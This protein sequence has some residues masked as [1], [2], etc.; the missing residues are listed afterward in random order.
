MS[1]MIRVLASTAMAVLLTLGLAGTAHAG[2]LTP[3]PAPGKVVAKLAASDRETVAVV[4]KVTDGDTF[5]IA[6]G[7]RVRVLGIDSCEMSTSGGKDAK[8]WADVLLPIG[9][10][11]T[12]RAEP[13]GKDKDKNGRLLRYVTLSDGQDFGAAMVIYD[14]TGIYRNGDPKVNDASPAEV[15]ALRAL[16]DGPRVCTIPAAAP[17]DDNTYVPAP[18]GNGGGESR[19]CRKRWWC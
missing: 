7:Q 18:N 1:T 11:V 10:Q 17:N 14:H 2:I 16:D 5:T 9:E 15:A 12:L 13:T 6:S 8:A 19:F 4:T 3:P